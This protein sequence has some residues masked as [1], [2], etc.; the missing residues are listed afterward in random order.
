MTQKFVHKVS[1]E[2]TDDAQYKSPASIP[3]AALTQGT[4]IELYPGTYTDMT[5]LSWDNVAVIG[6]GDKNE[7]I[8]SS[9]TVAN[10]SA[11]TLTFHNVTFSGADA[12]A[13]GDASAVEVLETDNA[14]NLEFF[15]CKFNTA[16]HAVR[17]HGTG[18]VTLNSVDA[19]GVD[20]AIV[21]NSVAYVNFSMLNTAANAYF[22]SGG[23]SNAD[24][25]VYV[26]ASTAGS[27]N[28]GATVETV[29]ALI[30]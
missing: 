7:I 28:V 9:M 2:L 4:S 11:N 13:A 10:T 12:N 18:T 24:P 16:E 14:S 22:Q 23:T 6:V 1:P 29:T 30:S 19:T 26:R 8:I 25:N 27:G 21:S 3:A 15:G 17:H 5:S 20:Q